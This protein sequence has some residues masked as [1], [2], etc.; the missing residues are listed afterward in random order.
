MTAAFSTELSH[1][2]PSSSAGIAQ[3]YPDDSPVLVN[4]PAVQTNFSPTSLA[5]WK[6][7]YLEMAELQDDAAITPY[8]QFGEV[9]WWYFPSAAGMTFYDDYTKTEFQSQFSRA[10]HVFTSNDDDPGPFPDE[11]AFLPDLIGDFTA[12][13]RS[14]VRATYP[15]TKFEV[16]YPHD[17]NDHA[18]TRV[19][20]F[21]DGDWTTTNLD[22]LK[23]ENFTYT[24][25]Q[26]LNKALESI[27]FPLVMGFPRA[28]SA[29]LVGVFSPSEPWNWERRL[30]RA[31]NIE[32]VVLWA[33]D[34]FSMV[35]YRMPLRR[36]I[37]RS[38]FV[39]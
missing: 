5:F 17:V 16:L 28:E 30:A 13:I 31:E 26:Q 8:L 4:T 2:D 18:L 29:H 22:V 3:R 37:L 20:N 27:R 33:F 11:A 10:M 39:A 7:V 23:T 34:Q 19:V 21:P 12:S 15:T 36:G 35:G 14:F 24:G 25:N 38:R 6:Q 32:S 9:Q 1:G